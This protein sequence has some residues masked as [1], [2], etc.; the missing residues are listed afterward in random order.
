MHLGDKG[1]L[2]L[3]LRHLTKNQPLVYSLSAFY[4]FNDLFH[5][6]YVC[7]DVVAVRCQ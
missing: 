5:S 1:F 2:Q 3:N 6:L 7:V 4:F